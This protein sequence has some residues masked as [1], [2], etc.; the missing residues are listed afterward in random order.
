[1]TT[2]TY[3]D[4]R[5]PIETLTR[6]ALVNEGFNS[7]NIFLDNAYQE[8]P[9]SKTPWATITISFPVNTADVIGCEPMERIVGTCIVTIYSPRQTGSR[10][11]E[12]YASAVLRSWVAAAAHPWKDPIHFH[13][14]NREGP[15][16]LNS[17]RNP[18]HMTTTVSCRF[19]A[20]V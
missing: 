8:P 10:T 4:V 5:G 11:P 17:Q 20:Q 7:S 3:Q 19:T 1:M 2:A 15:I 6:T 16:H 9:Y 13:T 18:A 12:R 14:S